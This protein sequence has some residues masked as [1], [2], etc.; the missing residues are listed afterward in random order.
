MQFIK[1]PMKT[2]T[3]ILLFLI[4]TKLFSQ[5]K[6]IF[7]I[8]TVFKTKAEI[9]KAIKSVDSLNNKIEFFE[10]EKYIVYSIC[11]GEWGGAILFKN[12]QSNVKFICESTCPVIITKFNNKYIVTNTLNHL[13]PSTEVLEIVNPEK[14]NI[15][16][17]DDEKRSNYEKVSQTGAKKLIDVYQCGTLFSFV[18]DKKLYHII[19]DKDGTYIAEILNGKFNKL[20]M[21][22][23]KNLWT[24][25]PN[26]LNT[27]N[28]SV[29]TFINYK[30]TGYIEIKGNLISLFIA[31]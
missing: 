7:N 12:K 23:N 3:L 21:I 5:N 13:S 14:L 2:K 11:K 10:D 18:Y 8:K 22:S 28:S 17:N 30:D 31:K 6:N 26:I 20:E 19:S 29:V 27:K 25:N 15:A 4:S 1:N 16:T 24:Y 9:T